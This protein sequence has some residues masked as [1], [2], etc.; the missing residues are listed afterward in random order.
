MPARPAACSS[1]SLPSCIPGFISA[2]DGSFSGI[3]PTDGT[4]LILYANGI[5]LDEGSSPEGHF[6]LNVD[7]LDR[8]YIFKC[9]FARQGGPTTPREDT[10]PAIRLKADL[11]SRPVAKY[12]VRMEVDNPPTGSNLE[13]MLSRVAGGAFETD[14]IQKYPKP[15]L[16]H[17]GFSP[18]NLDGSLQFDAS[19]QDVTLSLNASGVEGARRAARLPARQRRRRD[20]DRHPR[21][22]LRLQCTGPGPLR[23]PADGGAEGRVA[24]AGGARSR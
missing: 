1:S 24:V 11:V 6:H 19:I 20:R 17:L 14:L 18:E 15:R 4:E 2:K 21:S 5:R 23:Q 12:P 9:T 7:G 16:Y 13:L 8:A 3:L 10:R 22:G